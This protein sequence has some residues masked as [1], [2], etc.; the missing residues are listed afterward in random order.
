MTQ[1]LVSLDTAEVE[2]RTAPGIGATTVFNIH[3]LGRTNRRARTI[4]LGVTVAAG[5]ALAGCG[6]E[7]P[8]AARSATTTARAAVTAAPTCSTASF[9]GMYLFEI[10]GDIK[11]SD[12]YRPALQL[13][14]I[15]F[16]GKGAGTLTSTSSLNFEETRLDI[17]YETDK[18]CSGTITDESGASYR[19]TFSPTG[20]EVSFFA[21]G[22]GA[23][24][25]LDGQADRVDDNPSATCDEGS[26]SGTYQYRARGAFGDQP[27]LEHGFEVYDGKGKVTNVF[28]VAGKDEEERLTG[29]YVVDEDCHAVVTYDTGVVLE[30]YIAADGSEF[31]WIQTAGFDEPGIFGGHERRVS[32]STDT[33]ITTGR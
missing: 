32:T 15:T 24:P 21:A 2:R 26:L 20:E 17:T 30:Q 19:A 29:T 7:T 11:S 13:G 33:T 31:F 27:H 9:D 4:T 12:G 28:R 22:A 25:N 14:S 5:L 23:Q 1:P 10:H 3:P 18:R 8:T 16:D 6:S